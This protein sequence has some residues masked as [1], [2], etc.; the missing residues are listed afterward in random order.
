MPRESPRGASSRSRLGLPDLTGTGRFVAANVIDSL[1]GGL[2]IGF[3]VVYFTRT[4]SL[5]LAEVGACLT[6]GNALALPV[7]ALAGRLL[8]RIGPQ[9]VVASGNVVSALGFVG[10]L[11]AQSAWQVVATQFLVQV[12][13]SMYWTSSSALVGL[14][15]RSDD[16]TRWFGFFRALRNVGIGF[17]GAIASLALATASTTGLR[18]M[19]AAQAASYLVAAWLLLGWRPGRTATCAY[20]T[21]GAPEDLPPP[22]RADAR[23]TAVLR[24]G[25]YMRLVAANL[26]FV[27]AS[28]VLSVLLGVY[29]TEELKAGAWAGG[30]LITLNT[31]LVAAAQTI[32]TRWIERHRPT[33][34]I[35]LASLVNAAAFGV[36][37]VLGL[38]P[39]WAVPVGLVAAVVVYTLAEVLGSPP[40]GELSVYLAPAHVRGRYLG[41]YQLSW[42]LGATVAPAVLTS[43]LALGPAV[44]WLFLAAC[45]LLAVPLVLGLEGR[46]NT[47]ERPARRGDPVT[48]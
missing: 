23:Y 20:D 9:S 37:A 34:V 28:M 7:P 41:V 42:S 27:L 32:A 16:R 3:L 44:P 29:A 25:A 11:F 15:A 6:L 10:L 35:A 5:S 14:V 1:A 2:V 12:G 36:F 31:A 48:T 24:D 4:T 21:E 45:S 38:V 22:R 17:G 46:G 26:S 33:R 19:V 39:G 40:M 30:V 47:A 18:T 43:L 8:D 13:S